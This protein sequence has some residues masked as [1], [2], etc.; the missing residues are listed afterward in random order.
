MDRGGLIWG[1]EGVDGSPKNEMESTRAGCSPT[2][3]VEAPILGG[4]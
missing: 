3:I 4:D 2:A 1:F